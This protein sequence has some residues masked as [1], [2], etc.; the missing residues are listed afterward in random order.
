MCGKVVSDIRLI[1]G[2]ERER[3]LSTNTHPPNNDGGTFAAPF[4]LQ[5]A[6]EGEDDC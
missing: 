4:T 5:K 6:L 1:Q 3:S 2:R